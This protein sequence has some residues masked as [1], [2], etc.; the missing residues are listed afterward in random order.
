MR[1]DIPSYAK[2][3][4]RESLEERQRLP[5]SKKFG[6][7]KQ[8]ARRLGIN[9]GVERAKQIVR[10]ESLSL[11]DAKRV[12]AFYERFKNCDTPKCEGAIGLWGGRRFG[13]K[14]STQIK[15]S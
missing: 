9:S 1:F 13:R 14:I 4:A 5:E 11:E 10:S 6:I 2:R 15:R 7:D 8:E 12:A 3:I